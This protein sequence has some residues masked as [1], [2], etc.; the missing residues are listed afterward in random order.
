MKTF[1]PARPA[2]TALAIQRLETM[3]CFVP[4][5]VS[6][7]VGA[8]GLTAAMPAL[9]SAPL[10]AAGERVQHYEAAVPDTV[11]EAAAVLSDKTAVLVSAYE[12]GDWN[13]V[14][15]ASYPLEA[16]LERLRQSGGVDAQALETAAATLERVHLA[17]E[18]EDKATL[19]A[20]VPVLETQLHALAEAARA[21]SG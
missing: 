5:L 11:V 8:G 13:S 3:R 9:A 20:D 12:A 16:A 19:D 7:I 17:S 10:E 2:P 21:A 4:V 18:E 1:R 14:H 15:E 6:L